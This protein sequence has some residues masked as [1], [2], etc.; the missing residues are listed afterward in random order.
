MPQAP[1]TGC[2]AAARGLGQYAEHDASRRTVVSG[3]DN[4]LLG[5]EYGRMHFRGKN[6]TVNTSNTPQ[7]VDDGS[8]T[9]VM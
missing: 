9:R 6:N 5:T 7:L 8:H 4:K 1:I 2:R 3:D